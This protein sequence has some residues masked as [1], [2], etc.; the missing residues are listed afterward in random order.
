MRHIRLWL[1]K[2]HRWGS[3]ALGLLLLVV[4]ISGVALVLDPEIEQVTHPSLYDTDPGPARLAPG[5]ALAIVHRSCRNSKPGA[6]SSRRTEA[7]GRC[8]RKPPETPPASTTPT[9]GCSARSTATT[10]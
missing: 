10:G 3:F 5:Q 6:A 1:A 2:G 4:V 9:A 7:P 8:T